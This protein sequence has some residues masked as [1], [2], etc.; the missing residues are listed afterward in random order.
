MNGFSHEGPARDAGLPE[1][2]IAALKDGKRPDFT[3]ED[4]RIVYDFATELVVSH[5]VGRPVMDRQLS[6][7]QL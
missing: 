4:E 6:G 1:P 7:G 5:E 3:A 2:V